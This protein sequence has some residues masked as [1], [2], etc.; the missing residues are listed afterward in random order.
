MPDLLTVPTAELTIGLTIGLIRHVRAADEYVRSGQFKGW[1]PMFYGLGIAGA[2]VGIVGMGPIGQAV[3]TRLKGWGATL[4]YSQP[5]ALPVA[6]EEALG[7]TRKTL[8]ALLAQSDIVILALPLTTLF[9]LCQHAVMDPVGNENPWFH[10]ISL[11]EFL[12]KMA[13]KAIHHRHHNEYDN[14]DGADFL[15][16]H[17]A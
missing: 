7:V 6:D 3:A 15:V 11:L 12:T 2:T 5:D 10:L 17:D 4:L 16:L 9:Q 1:Q 13:A 8:E 14:Q